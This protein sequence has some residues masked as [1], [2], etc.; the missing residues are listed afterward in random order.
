M[1]KIATSVRIRSQSLSPRNEM[2]GMICSGITSSN[3]KNKPANVFWVQVG[4]NAIS[5][6][7]DV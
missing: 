1:A 2:P 4:S 7:Y 6:G 5:D 3:T